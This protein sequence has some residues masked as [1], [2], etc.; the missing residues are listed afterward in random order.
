[1]SHQKP[2]GRDTQSSV[3]PRASHPAAWRNSLTLR[4]LQKN[5]VVLAVLGKLGWSV[6]KLSEG[7]VPAAGRARQT[8]Q[9]GRTK[10]DL[11]WKS[12]ARFL[13]PEHQ[14]SVMRRQRGQ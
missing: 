8:E 7:V 6:E 11:K 3:S 5:P 4:Q 14:G 12:R 10:S 13:I 1:M 9:I 2:Q